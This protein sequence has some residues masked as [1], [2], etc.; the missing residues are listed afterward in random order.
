MANI[1]SAPKSSF[2]GQIERKSDTFSDT[3][4]VHQGNTLACISSPLNEIETLIWEASQKWNIS[5]TILYDL[6]ICESRLRHNNIWGDNGLAYGIYQWHLSSWV[7]FNNI[8]GTELNITSIKD[9]I[10]MT[11]RVLQQPNGWQNWYNCYN[12]ISILP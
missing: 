12:Q 8:F 4:V 10:E 5:Y 2:N 9:Q 11:A 7:L 1:G 3:L 6:A